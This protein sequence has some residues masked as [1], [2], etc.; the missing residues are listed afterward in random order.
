VKVDLTPHPSAHLFDI[1]DLQSQPSTTTILSSPS[2]I[3]P[4]C[5]TSSLDVQLPIVMIQKS[6]SS[7]SSPLNHSAS[8]WIQFS[9]VSEMASFLSQTLSTS[10]NYPSPAPSSDLLQ[11]SIL[12]I[13]WS[14]STGTHH[15]HRLMQP[16]F[17]IFHVGTVET[18]SNSLSSHSQLS[19]LSLPFHRWLGRV[20]VSSTKV[21]DDPNSNIHVDVCRFI[22]PM[23]ME[24]LSSTHI[25]AIS[26]SNHLGIF[27]TL[28]ISVSHFDSAR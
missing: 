7:L 12:S 23:L 10:S 6:L 2:T 27:P 13:E 3:A 24:S 5:P 9:S 14:I 28:L 21:S 15:R 1:A 20:G 8:D 18:L 4:W 17:D 25:F 26:S 19:S 22:T 16:Q 11:P